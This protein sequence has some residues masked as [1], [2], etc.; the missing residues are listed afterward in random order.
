MKIICNSVNFGS[1]VISEDIKSS[2]EQILI[3][4]KFVFKRKCSDELRLNI[5]DKLIRQGWSGNIKVDPKLK[6][7]ITSLKDKVGLCLQTGNISRI[8]A[9]LLKLQTL[10]LNNKIVSA[11]YILPTNSAGKKMGSNI[12]YM[13]RLLSELKIYKHTITLPIYVLGI[14]EENINA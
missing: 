2:I 10:Y 8:Y 14:E 13:E 6:I 3:N 4:E 9:D 1:N 5:M 11:I 12:A 7:T